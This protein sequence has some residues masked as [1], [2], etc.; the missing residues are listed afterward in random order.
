MYFKIRKKRKKKKTK[1]NS[2]PI[3]PMSRPPPSS[4]PWPSRRLSLPLAAATYSLSLSPLMHA[5]N[6]S[7]EAPRRPFLFPP[8]SIK[9]QPSSSPSPSPSSLSKPSW[10]CRREARR[11]TAS[12]EPRHLTGARRSSLDRPRRS[13]VQQS[14]A[15]AYAL[16]V[17][18]RSRYA[19][20]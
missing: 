14:S 17:V 13:V 8:F 5:I 1:P 7:H 20:A 3:R 16:S 15:R 2:K 19:F 10:A 9:G 6:G 11:Q 18:H 12:T 4:S